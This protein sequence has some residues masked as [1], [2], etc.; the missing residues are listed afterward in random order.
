MNKLL[1][2]ISILL[3]NGASALEWEDLKGC[4]HT[5]KYNDNFLENSKDN[6]SVINL[7]ENPL[8]FL[9]PD[10][11]E[12]IV[13]SIVLYKGQEK[14]YHYQDIYFDDGA[15][16]KSYGTLIS[17]FRSFVRYRFSPEK[18]LYLTNELRARE[19]EAGT[20][21][22]IAFN[23]YRHGSESFIES[24]RFIIQRTECYGE[25]ETEEILTK[26]LKLPIKLKL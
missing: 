26:G 9:A 6:Y 19:I 22:I 20:Y 23:K 8:F 2:I 1:L 4:Y 3:T 5:V 12:F 14:E 13:H 18:I 21:E 17:N 24:G 7:N 25:I 11:G 16:S 15:E 10:E